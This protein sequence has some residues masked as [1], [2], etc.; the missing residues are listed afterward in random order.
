MPEEWF[1]WLL[2]HCSVTWSYALYSRMLCVRVLV[3]R[4]A[5][6]R[7]LPSFPGQVRLTPKSSETDGNQTTVKEGETSQL[8]LIIILPSSSQPL[9]FLLQK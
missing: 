7:S 2:A 9:Q 3:T 1:E 8:P 5:L 4:K 6:E